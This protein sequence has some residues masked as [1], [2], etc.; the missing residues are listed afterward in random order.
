MF[1]LVA[2]LGAALA[3]ACDAIKTGGVS[4]L[5]LANWSDFISVTQD[6]DGT[7]T[8]ITMQPATVFYKFAF[9]SNGRNSQRKYW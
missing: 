1:T 5:Y 6:P 8:A 4:E 7:V 2:C 3:K 9:K